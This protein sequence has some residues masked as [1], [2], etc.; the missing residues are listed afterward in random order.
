MEKKNET[1]QNW[2]QVKRLKHTS[3]RQKTGFEKVRGLY[4][5]KRHNQEQADKSNRGQPR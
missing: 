2:A 1:P 4:E 5:K 3:Q